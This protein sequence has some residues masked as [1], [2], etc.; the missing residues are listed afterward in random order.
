MRDALDLKLIVLSW[1][2]QPQS[3]QAHVFHRADCAGDIHQFARATQH[4]HDIV[5]R[6]RI[7]HMWGFVPFFESSR[8]M[9]VWEATRPRTPRRGRLAPHPGEELRPFEPWI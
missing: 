5:E 1:L 9:D 4:H 8:K 2:H 7:I 6:I 3:P